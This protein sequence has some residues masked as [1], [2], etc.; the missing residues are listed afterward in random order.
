MHF[1]KTSCQVDTWREAVVLQGVHGELPEP[2]WE[3]A[4]VFDQEPLLED[5]PPAE[6]AFGDLVSPLAQDKNYGRGAR[7]QESSL[8]YRKVRVLAVRGVG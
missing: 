2:V 1:V 3:A 8:P 4:M 6:G 5:E 7:A